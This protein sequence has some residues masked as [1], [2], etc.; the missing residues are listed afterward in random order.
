MVFSAIPTEGDYGAWAPSCVDLM[1]S[2]EYRRNADVDAL[3]RDVTQTSN[4]NN[5]KFVSG[6]A[7]IMVELS[8]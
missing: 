3:L 2:C 1:K 7:S 8:G 4:W 5:K 6:V